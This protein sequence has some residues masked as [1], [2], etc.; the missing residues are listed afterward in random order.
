LNRLRS[1]LAGL[2]SSFDGFRR[3]SPLFDFATTFIDK[4]GRDGVGRLTAVVTYYAFFSLFPM[5]LVFVSVLGMLLN[6]PRRDD[7]LDS[8]LANFPVLGDDITGDIGTLEGRGMTLLIGLVAAIWA[9]THAFEAFEYAMHVVWHGTQV[10]LPGYV[11]RRLRAL[12]MMLLF[13]GAV[14]V[15]TAATIISAK[16]TDYVGWSPHFGILGAGAVNAATLL[17]MFQVSMPKQQSWKALAPGAITGGFGLVGLQLLGS[18]YIDRVVAGATNTYGVFA[19]VLGLLSWLQLVVTLT[20][21]SAELNS[22][23]STRAL[24][25][26]PAAAEYLDSLDG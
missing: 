21:Y 6:G 19:G 16:V 11:H 7:I 24:R 22:V 3:K 17:V 20:I 23:L 18:W 9:G 4:I 14:L 12:F 8:A 13:G 2:R 25:P 10:R 5:L 26:L 1:V 15:S